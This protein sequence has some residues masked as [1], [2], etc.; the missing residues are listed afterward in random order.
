MHFILPSYYDT[1]NLNLVPYACLTTYLPSTTYY[2][3]NPETR[4][5]LP[6]LVGDATIVLFIIKFIYNFMISLF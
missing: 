6:L 3:Q 5:L 2:R 1:P 4:R